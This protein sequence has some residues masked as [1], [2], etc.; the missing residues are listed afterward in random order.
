[1]VIQYLALDVVCFIT[2]SAVLGYLLITRH[3]LQSLNF[4]HNKPPPTQ[5][6]LRV[7]RFRYGL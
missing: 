2:T 1:M 5:G 6:V 3:L 7:V 4:R